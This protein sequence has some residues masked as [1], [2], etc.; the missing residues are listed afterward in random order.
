MVGG[1]NDKTNFP[2]KLFLTNTQVS[3]IRKA[4]AFGSSANITF[5]AT[6][7]SI[8]VQLGGFLGRLLGPLLKAGLALMKSVLKGCVRYIFASLFLSLNE[9]T[10]QTGRKALSK[11]LFV[12]EKI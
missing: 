10:C 2:C 7:L 9:S 8:L 12:L 6:Q 3:R 1:Y 4:F 11:A 5:S